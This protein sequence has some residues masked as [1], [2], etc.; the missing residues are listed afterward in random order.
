MID[1]FVLAPDVI[2]RVARSSGC[3][4]TTGRGVDFGNYQCWFENGASI[5]QC[6]EP[7]KWTLVSKCDDTCK[8]LHNDRP[9]CL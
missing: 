7:G 1:R 5:V 3:S 8:T 4:T 6:V 9:Y 2:H